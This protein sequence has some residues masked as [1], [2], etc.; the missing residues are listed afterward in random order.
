MGGFN[1]AVLLFKGDEVDPQ[2]RYLITLT[3]AGYRTFLIPVLQFSFINQEELCTAL[4]SAH[5]YS[6]IIFSSPRCVRAVEQVW[7]FKIY[8]HWNERKVFVVGPSTSRAVKDSLHL[9]TEGE[10]TGS[11]EALAVLIRK[12][13]GVD[14]S[15]KKKLLP[16]LYPCSSLA[17]ADNFT[18][19]PIERI[20]A[21]ETADCVDLRS[22]EQVAK[23]RV[24]CAF[25]S[26]SGV[27]A[28][29]KELR[30]R[31]LTKFRAV[32]IGTTTAQA[33]SNE[34][35]PA[36]EIC[37]KPSPAALKSALKKVCSREPRRSVTCLPT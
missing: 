32:A 18:G 2:D 11:A 5:K 14:E 17:D 22:I 21:Y 8:E 25:F 13:L 29:V 23:E 36:D 35:H 26:P 12:S 34:G 19:L 1:G 10:E 30:K 3:E 20:S 33:L 9:P 27:R 16:L 24:V 6:G 28:A 7:S 15:S 4:K 31:G 37:E